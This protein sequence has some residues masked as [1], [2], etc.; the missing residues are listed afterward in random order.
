MVR[1]WQIFFSGE[2]GFLRSGKSF[3][4][5]VT[6]QKELLVIGYDFFFSQNDNLLG[7]VPPSSFWSIPKYTW[8]WPRNFAKRILSLSGEMKAACFNT[9]LELLKSTINEEKIS[10]RA[11]CS[12]GNWTHL[13]SCG[14]CQSHTE[15]QDHSRR[16]WRANCRPLGCYDYVG[17]FR[18]PKEGKTSAKRPQQTLSN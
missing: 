16:C 17:K 11:L 10:T 18:S 1:Y 15:R 4:L 8:I 6:S 12:G 7:C 14:F 13:F 3:S 9:S 5:L 2:A